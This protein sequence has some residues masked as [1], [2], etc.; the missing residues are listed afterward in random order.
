VNAVIRDLRQEGFW[1]EP[2]EIKMIGSN[3][4]IAKDMVALRDS[5]LARTPTRF[6]GNR[7][8]ELA[9][10]EAHIYPPRRVFVF[11]YR[12]RGQTT[13]WDAVSPGICT[14]CDPG[15]L[16][17]DA[18][19]RVDQQGGKVIITVYSEEGLREGDAAPAE[20]LANQE[21]KKRFP[22]HGV[23]YLPEENRA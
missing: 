14:P 20:E 3:D 2:L 15:D 10:E 9:F 22:G 13:Q 17:N 11:E 7:F 16:W 8:G 1:I 21:F 18:E 6:R 4:P 5:R 12:R 19:V 23:I